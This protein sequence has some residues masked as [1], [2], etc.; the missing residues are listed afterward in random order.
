MTDLH[1]WR[2][3][4]AVGLTIAVGYVICALIFYLWPGASMEF[5]NSLFHGLDFRKLEPAA[6]WSLTTFV[7]TVVIFA[8]WGFLMGALFAALYNRIP[9][10]AARGSAP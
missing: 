7:C 10:S 6:P 5:M 3:G 9:G 1:P 2:T 4:M 8:I